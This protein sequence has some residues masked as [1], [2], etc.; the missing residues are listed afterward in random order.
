MESTLYIRKPVAMI[1]GLAADTVE[2][3]C[4]QARGDRTAGPAA[5]SAII[6]FSNRRNFR[7]GTGKKSF[8][9]S[10]IPRRG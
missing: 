2:K 3:H 9:G 10:N 5:D 1:S 6:K 7:C 4:L 8:V